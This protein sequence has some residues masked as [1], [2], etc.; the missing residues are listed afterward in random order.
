MRLIQHQEE[1]ASLSKWLGR[2]LPHEREL[3]RETLQTMGSEKGLEALLHLHDVEETKRQKRL[4][5]HY[6]VSSLFA[7]GMVGIVLVIDAGFLRSVFQHQHF[8]PSRPLVY[9]FLLLQSFFA[10]RGLWGSS[11]KRRNTPLF[12][13]IVQQNV[14]TALLDY[15]NNPLIADALARATTYYAGD[16]SRLYTRLA[17][18]LPLLPDDKEALTQTARRTL[19]GR[20]HTPALVKP[21]ETEAA[22]LSLLHSAIIVYRARTEKSSGLESPRRLEKTLLKFYGG[23]I[24]SGHRKQD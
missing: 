21:S 6:F 7:A 15:G 14:I 4:L 5:Q 24:S 22:A 13:T 19:L 11:S 8:S 12:S 9:S 17:Q 20:L 23:L 1:P 2:D 18:I 10:L 3:M 16:R